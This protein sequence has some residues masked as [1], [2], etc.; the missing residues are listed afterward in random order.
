MREMKFGHFKEEAALA[1]ASLK[2]RHCAVNSNRQQH[3]YPRIIILQGTSSLIE[4][5]DGCY[6]KSSHHFTHPK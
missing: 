1:P 4:Q 6:L 5:V 3:I 2:E